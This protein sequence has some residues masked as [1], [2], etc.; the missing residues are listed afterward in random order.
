LP[1]R[2]VPD[3]ARLLGRHLCGR[4]APSTRALSAPLAPGEPSVQADL[5]IRGAGTE[6]YRCPLSARNPSVQA[7]SGRGTPKS[8]WAP[9]SHVLPSRWTIAHRPARG[10][11][12][13]DREQAGMPPCPSR[14]RF[15]PPFVPSRPAEPSVQADPRCEGAIIDPFFG[16]SIGRNPSV[17]ARSGWDGH[18]PFGV[19]NESRCLRPPR[20]LCSPASD[21]A[22]WSPVQLPRRHAVSATGSLRRARGL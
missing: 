3:V 4:R 16:P 22:T 9:E 14:A 6:P 5:C 12:R 19:K 1:P 10:P 15:S 11:T 18:P 17:Q 20:N 2:S 8:L 13:G 21:G 7:R